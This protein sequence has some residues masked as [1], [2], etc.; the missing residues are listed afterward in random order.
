MTATNLFEFD[1]EKHEG[2]ILTFFRVQN[3]F[4][5]KEKA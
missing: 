5:L 1:L 2:D 3:D 4:I